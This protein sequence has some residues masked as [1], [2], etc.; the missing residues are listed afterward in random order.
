MNNC[1]QNNRRRRRRRHHHHHHHR[2]RR[3]R[4]RLRV[5]VFVGITIRRISR[6]IIQ[7]LYSLG[8]I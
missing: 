6:F 4:H 3:R 2:R 7:F 1:C 5:F 8:A